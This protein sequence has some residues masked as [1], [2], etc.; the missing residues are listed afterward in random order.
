MSSS[1]DDDYYLV[2]TNTKAL[3]SIRSLKTKQ[4][5]KLRLKLVTPFDGNK[6]QSETKTATL[7]DTL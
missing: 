7:P 4:K 6:N 1:Y 3:S 2:K 5:S